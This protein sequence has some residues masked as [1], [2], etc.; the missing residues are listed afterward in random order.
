MLY[1][2]KLLCRFL[3]EGNSEFAALP[4]F[5]VIPAFGGFSDLFTGGVPGLDIELSKVNK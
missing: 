4:T 1:S 2:I 3:F 5:G